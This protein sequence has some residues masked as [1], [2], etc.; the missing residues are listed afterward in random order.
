[1]AILFDLMT[2][3]KTSI[4]NRGLT[5]VSSA[6]VL[7][8]KVPTT[9]P[10][11]LPG[12]P[13]TY[14]CILLAPYGPEGLD[15]NAGTNIRDDVVY[16]VLLAILAADNQDQAQSFNK[17][18]TWRESLRKLFHNQPFPNQTTA[19]VNGTSYGSGQIAW[20]ILVTPLDVVDR[21][22]W[23]KNVFA[24]A[25]VLNATSREGRG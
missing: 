3:A 16:K 18:L 5:G 14:P 9:K 2:L 20:H 15:P 11:V 22:Q 7:I 10:S 13:V 19:T 6:N 4:V 8:Q 21:D 1:V 23:F 12:K 24:S 17:Y 25:M